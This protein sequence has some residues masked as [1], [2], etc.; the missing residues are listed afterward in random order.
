[1]IDLSSMFGAQHIVAPKWLKGSGF[2]P[3]LRGNELWWGSPSAFL[4]GTPP[5]GIYYR[6]DDPHILP[7]DFGPVG[8]PRQVEAYVRTVHDS[9]VMRDQLGETCA[10][11]NYNH[12]RIVT[13]CFP[14]GFRWFFYPEIEE[15]HPQLLVAM[16]HGMRSETEDGNPFSG[17]GMSDSLE[18][19]AFVAPIAQNVQY[20]LTSEQIEAMMP[21]FSGAEI[22]RIDD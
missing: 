21:R 18:P 12:L 9:V 10:L 8:T 3:I 13:H 7:A 1:M 11:I 20:Y 22:G 16:L 4:K 14:Q 6:H 15:G 19:C 2:C 5:E 17:E